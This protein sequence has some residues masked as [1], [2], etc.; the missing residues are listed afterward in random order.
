VA[1]LY[2][3]KYEI[4]SAKFTNHIEKITILQSLLKKN[5]I[6]TTKELPLYILEKALLIYVIILL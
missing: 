6:Y 3:G 4:Y 5:L 2:H 1:S